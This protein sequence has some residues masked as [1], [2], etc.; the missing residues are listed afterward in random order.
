MFA[1]AS[2]AG[3]VAAAAVAIWWLGE[4]ALARGSGSSTALSTSAL[5]ALVM[6]QLFSIVTF[7]PW[8]GA[9]TGPRSARL[10]L[11][12]SL[13]LPWPLVA[14]VWSATPLPGW[15]MVQIEAAL[16]VLALLLPWAGAA[17]RMRA[18]QPVAATLVSLASVI[19]VCALWSVR[20]VLLERL[21]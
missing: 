19:A 17:V 1:A 21:S 10:T 5:Q 20:D 12:C 16:A 4:V 6:V 14:L 15:T 18:P 13:A 9:T 11:L 8:L 3:W 7:G 2:L